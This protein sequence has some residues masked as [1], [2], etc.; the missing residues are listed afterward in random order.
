[1]C[2]F[3]LQLLLGQV[4]VVWN[5]SLECR[6]SPSTKKF[7]PIILTVSRS[8][9]MSET[10]DMQKKR[11]SNVQKRD[12]RMIVAE[13]L[14]TFQLCANVTRTHQV[15]TKTVIFNWPVQLAS[16]SLINSTLYCN[17][18]FNYMHLIY[19]PSKHLFFLLISITIYMNYLSYLKIE[20]TIVLNSLTIIHI[21]NLLSQQKKSINS[22]SNQ[23]SD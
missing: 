15:Y 2:H 20:R 1:M 8:I 16:S 5:G 3:F 10:Q 7:S 22:Y 14:S 17:F 4:F 11:V 21:Q 12:A 18:F 19:F 6:K 9:M 13:L 23:T